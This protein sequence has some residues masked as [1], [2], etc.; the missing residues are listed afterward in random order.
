[1]RAIQLHD[2]LQ[3]LQTPR[4]SLARV[5]GSSARTESSISTA[6]ATALAAAGR[7]VVW[8]S[9][10]LNLF[11]EKK[12]HSICVLSSSSSISSTITSLLLQLSSSA[13]RSGVPRCDTWR[14]SWCRF[15]RATSGVEVGGVPFAFLFLAMALAHVV[16]AVGAVGTPAAGCTSGG[17]G[18]VSVGA[19]EVAPG[20]AHGGGI[21]QFG[22]AVW[23]RAGLPPVG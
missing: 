12:S 5:A 1:M 17:T 19:V 6:T 10:I 23:Y 13:N 21:V 18:G 4:E 16:G 9:K 7:G 3:W 20:V 14:F 11:L 22:A 2:A 15:V 8:T